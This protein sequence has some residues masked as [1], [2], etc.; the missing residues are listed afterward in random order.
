MKVEYCSL[1]GK[2]LKLNT[3]EDVAQYVAEIE[4]LDGL[5]TVRL[6]GNTFGVEAARAIAA[7]LKKKDQ[8]ECV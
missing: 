6:G 5:T 4:A 3:V 8:L 7:A 2:G 1:V